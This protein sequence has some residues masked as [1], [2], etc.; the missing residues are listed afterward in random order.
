MD[1][2]GTAKITRYK[3]FF[4]LNKKNQNGKNTFPQ[5]HTE[6]MLYLDRHTFIMLSETSLCFK[7][8]V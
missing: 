5:G 8:N 4:K 2:L 7:G 6:T 3:I 1:G